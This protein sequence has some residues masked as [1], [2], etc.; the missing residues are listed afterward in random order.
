M[1]DRNKASESCSDDCGGW[2][3]VGTTNESIASIAR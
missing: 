1:V 3:M 2:A